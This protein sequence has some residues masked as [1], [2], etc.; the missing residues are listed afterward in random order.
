MKEQTLIA[1]SQVTINA[2]L[3]EVWNALVN[4]EK[5]KSYMFG[6]TVDTDWK[7]G[8]KITWKGEW[9]GK[10]YEDKGVILQCRPFRILQYT[11][12][13]PLTGERDVPENYHTVTIELMEKD[14]HTLV[15]LS[16]DNN[17]SEETK[18]HSQKNWEMVLSGLK[19][20]VESE[21]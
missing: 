11:H 9:N 17:E 6:T 13:S 15:T 1:A 12:F 7:A 14:N 5:I 10:H 16:Q 2:R 21:S 19:K 3:E 4:P 8:S 20:M 18:E